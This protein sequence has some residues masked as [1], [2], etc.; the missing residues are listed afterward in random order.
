MRTTENTEGIDR[1]MW[2]KECGL[3]SV[4]ECKERGVTMG[5]SKGCSQSGSR[6]PPL[7]A[8]RAE[9]ISIRDQLF[10][11]D[12][13][14]SVV[15]CRKECLVEKAAAPQAVIPLIRRLA[16]RV[17]AKV[18][19]V[20]AASSLEVL[21]VLT[22]ELEWTSDESEEDGLDEEPCNT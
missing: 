1:L 8:G 6:L 14:R 3:A 5:S 19:P 11:I 12:R 7:R 18:A 2:I 17:L 21:L 4:K 13:E 20:V 10:D 16:L 15:W 9:S 22:G